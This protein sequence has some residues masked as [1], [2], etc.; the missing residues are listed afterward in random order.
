MY[1]V[2]DLLSYSLKDTWAI[3]WLLLIDT[4]YTA[5]FSRIHKIIVKTASWYSFMCIEFDNL[6]LI[7]HCKTPFLRILSLG[8]GGTSSGLRTRV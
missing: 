5:I 3:R 6:A 4:Q 2:T 8:V 1:L 7:Y